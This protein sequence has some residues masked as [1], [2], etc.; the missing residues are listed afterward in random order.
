MKITT[1]AF[2]LLAS[3]CTLTLSGVSAIQENVAG[4]VDWHRPQLGVSIL[5]P[6]PP[7][8]VK[9]PG[10]DKKGLVLSITHSN[11]LGAVDEDTGDIGEFIEWL[12]D[13]SND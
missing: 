13:S 12:R 7:Q 2:A 4:V 3:V 8:I 5:T 6:T 1:R 11:V 10:D 9:V